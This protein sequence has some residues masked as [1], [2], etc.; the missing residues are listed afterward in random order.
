MSRDMYSRARSSLP[1]IPQAAC[2]HHYNRL[3]PHPL[4]V[5]HRHTTQPLMHIHTHAR[6]RMHAHA[7]AVRRLLFNDWWTG[8][9]TATPVQLSGSGGQPTLQFRGFFGKYSYSVTTAAGQAL[10]GAVEFKAALGAAQA[11]TIKLPVM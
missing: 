1:S 6:A 9:V 11:I 5:L 2:L 8:N 3:P 7:Q 4:P 10:S